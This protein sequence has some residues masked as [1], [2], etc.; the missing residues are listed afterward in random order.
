MKGL[1]AILMTAAVGVASVT[2]NA[3]A[4]ERTVYRCIQG[5]TVS[6][7]TFK[8]P[9]AKCEARKIKDTAGKPENVFGELGIVHGN[10]Y[11]GTFNGQPALTTRKTQGFTL[12]TRFTVVTPK[13]SPAHEGLGQVG[14]AKVDAFN[15]QFKDA[16]RQHKVDEALLRAI[17]HAESGFNATVVSPKGAQGVMQ[18][19]PGTAKELGVSNAFDAAQSIN[20]G[21]RYLK[22]L[23]KRFDGD[24]TKVIAAYNAGPG[25]VNKYRGVPPYRETVAYLDK[26][27]ALLLNYQAA[28]GKARKPLPILK[29]AQ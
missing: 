20:G 23:S 18:L 7:S 6:I 4:Q 9:R 8:E 15:Q 10:L 19:M 3:N 25:A 28:L 1:N 17:A 24:L 11:E 21:A 13:A 27:N 16:A 26:V 12:L 22:Q 14:K 29:A 2:F 5:N